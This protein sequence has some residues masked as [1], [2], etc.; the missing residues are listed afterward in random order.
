MIAFTASTFALGQTSS[1]S[2]ETHSFTG[3]IEKVLHDF[4]H[5]LRSISGAFIVAQAGVENYESLVEMPGSEQ[6]YIARYSS[7]EDTTASWQARMYRDDDFKRAATH[8]REL[9]QKL[10]ACH[11]RL[12]DGSL[13]FLN[14]EWDAPKEEND[15]TMSTLRLIT[16]DERYKE[17]KIDIEMLYQFPEWVI[18]IN[19]VSKKKDTLEGYAGSDGM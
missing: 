17:V 4:P 15:F 3:T 1:P 6:C 19:I 5:N 18:N 14:G 9:Y 11:L 7:V 10:K 8:Y 2:P 12:V 13:I 16:G